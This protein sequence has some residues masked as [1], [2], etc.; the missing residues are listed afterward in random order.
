MAKIYLGGG[1]HSFVIEVD[2][3]PEE[4]DVISLDDKKVVWCASEMMAEIL[5]KGGSFLL[6][7]QYVDIG[8]EG[9]LIPHFSIKVAN[10]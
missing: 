2:T 4:G 9:E 5:E 1:A 6:D 7:E 8:F 3:I 10:P